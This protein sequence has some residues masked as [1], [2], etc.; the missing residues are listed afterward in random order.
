MVA[1]AGVPGEPCRRVRVIA[2]RPGQAV[3]DDPIERVREPVEQQRRAGP[4]DSGSAL[5]DVGV[6]QVEPDA[7]HAR[8]G[9]VDRGEGGSIR[10]HAQ[11][12]PLA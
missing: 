11:V 9:M 6:G 2:R 10:F 5:F 7:L 1:E 12:G 3:L 8:V 4:D